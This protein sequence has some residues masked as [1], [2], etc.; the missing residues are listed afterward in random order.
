MHIQ[1]RRESARRAAEGGRARKERVDAREPL[2]IGLRMAAGVQ[3]PPQPY[4][5]PLLYW[6]AQFEAGLPGHFEFW[7]RTRTRNP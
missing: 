2:L 1:P 3:G 7:R 5:L 6:D 4:Q